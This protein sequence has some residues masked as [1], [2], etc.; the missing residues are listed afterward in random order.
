MHYSGTRRGLAIACCCYT[1]DIDL[2]MKTHIDS[3]NL[4][5]FKIRV[6]PR[7]IIRIQQAGIMGKLMF[8]HINKSNISFSDVLLYNCSKTI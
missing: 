2:V 4:S 6:K 5:V 8:T 1:N 3:S 7:D